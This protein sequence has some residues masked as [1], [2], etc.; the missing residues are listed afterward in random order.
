MN[1]TQ[2]TM[3]STSRVPLLSRQCEHEK[4]PAICTAHRPAGHT[5]RSLLICALIASVA[6]CQDFQKAQQSWNET[7]NARGEHWR[8]VRCD[9]KR[10]LAESQL[11]AGQLDEALREIDAALELNPADAPSHILLA[12]I[13]LEQGHPAAARRAIDQALNLQ[14]QN[15]EALFTAGLVAERIENQE[16]AYTFYTKA[17][18]VA[19]GNADY[20]AAQAETLVALGRVSDALD[21]VES[22]RPDFAEN[23]RLHDLAAELYRALGMKSES[24]ACLRKAAVAAGDDP[25]LA[26]QLGV[27]LSQAGQDVEAVGLLDPLMRR[28]EAS[29]ANSDKPSPGR[30]V[31]SDAAIIRLS[32]AGSQRRLGRLDAA[33]RAIDAQLRADPDDTQAWLLLARIELDAAEWEAALDAA[34]HAIRLSEE[35]PEARLMHAIA[36][37]KSG[38]YRAAIKS[39]RIAVQRDTADTTALCLIGQCHEARGERDE[40]RE[41]YMAALARDP[42][43]DVALALLKQFD[44][45]RA[46]NSAPPPP[47]PAGELRITRAE[48]ATE[49]S[50]RE[51]PH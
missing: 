29:P 44:A 19:P 10:R 26:A 34:G 46:R 13:Q 51:W 43:C 48:G 25:K 35:S 23:P 42:A 11:Q 6:G 14:P 15:G 16:E 3:R 24:I 33:R 12:R 41:A 49:I 17:A 5:R 36:A 21:L 40:A 39:A 30:S 50:M 4:S 27:A 8:Q 37:M 20:L 31:D 32:L 7:K 2:A 28:L 9:V 22:R 47:A 45:A 1:A 38:D 18:S